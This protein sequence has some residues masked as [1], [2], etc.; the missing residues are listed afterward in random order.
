MN[1]EFKGT[2][3]AL[4]EVINA[5]PHPEEAW[6]K[7]VRG[8]GSALGRLAPLLRILG[9]EVEIDEKRSNDS[10]RSVIRKIQE[11]PQS[12]PANARLKNEPSIVQ[13]AKNHVPE[14]EYEEF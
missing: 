12:F 5:D 3:G 10:Y 2:I 6:P 1:Q 9:Y 8:F 7:S 4:Y 14:F 11:P 13:Y